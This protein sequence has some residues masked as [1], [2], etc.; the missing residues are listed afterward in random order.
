MPDVIT[1]DRGERFHKQRL[2]PDV[3]QIQFSSE[4]KP[5]ETKKPAE[6]IW[7]G[8]TSLKPNIED[9]LEVAPAILKTED[10]K[11][12]RNKSEREFQIGLEKA[13]AGA[14]QV[15][16]WQMERARVLHREVEKQK[17]VPGPQTAA[18]RRAGFAATESINFFGNPPQT[19][20]LTANNQSTKKILDETTTKILFPRIANFLGVR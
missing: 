2:G 11:A 10:R 5:A 15:L 7:I 8:G 18:E 20:V 14:S 19:R 3:P 4:G 17:I 9:P 16:A 6:S 12:K 13:S 1:E